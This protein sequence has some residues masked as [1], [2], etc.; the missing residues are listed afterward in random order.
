VSDQHF[1]FWPERVPHS[2]TLPETTLCYNL[3][4]SA[5][6]YPDKTAIA[7]YGGELTYRDLLDQVN[8][9][10]GYLTQLG[11]QP[12]DRVLLYMHNCPQFIIAY[13]A[14]LR[15]NAVVV[16]LNS[17]IVTNEVHYFARDS[18]ARIAFASQD[19]YPQIAPLL[20]EG[21]LSRIILTA[22]SE[23]TGAAPD[24]EIPSVA[25]EERRQILD[26]GVILWRDALAAHHA[27]GEL[28]AASH[29]FALLVYTSGTTGEP[30]GCMHTHRTVMANVVGGAVWAQGTVE[31]VVLATLPLF[32]VTGMQGSMNAPVY[33]GATVVLMTRW[34]R[35]T[36]AF[37]IQR[38]GC[39]GWTNIST[40]MIDFLANPRIG[41][42]DLHTLEGI[43]GGGAPLPAAVGGR[44]LEMTGLHYVEGYG[45]SETI[46]QTHINPS[47]RPKM[48]CLGIPV[49]DVDAR[50]ID[51]ATLEDLG[52]NQEGEIILSGPQI[53]TGYWKR[54]EDTRQVFTTRGGKR[55]FRT[56]DLGY[57][58]EEGYF[59]YVDRIKRMINAS[60]FKVWPA[61]VE[62]LL[63]KHPA[64]QEACVIGIPDS[65]RGETVMAL[66]TLREAYRDTTTPEEIIEWSKGEMAAYKYPRVIEFRDTL[67]HSG[68]GKILWRILSEEYRR[69]SENPSGVHES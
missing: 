52:P 19:L 69:R 66:V 3:E 43:G 4:V 14:I 1:A 27:P 51:P 49:F 35:D 15:A 18:E 67:P 12:G 11:V 6:R 20:G 37:L 50:V 53:F 58:D 5:T 60:G 47:D 10:A 40:M 45:L 55:F 23:Y 54:P 61:E 42:Y 64:V 46:A 16:P 9:M 68:S 22:Y 21:A 17:L 57:Y 33:L 44:L 30:K 26:P 29:D 24:I 8:R 41:E 13:Y 59:F 38:Y 36:A 65:R 32:H 34:N 28:S 39:T 56:G 7:Y 2:L 31:S 48:Q 25:L 63:Y 62:T